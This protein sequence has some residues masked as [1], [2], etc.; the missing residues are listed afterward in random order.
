[1]KANRSCRAI[2]V[3]LVLVSLLLPIGA[4]ADVAD[5]SVWD[6]ILGLSKHYGK[7]VK[8]YN[9]IVDILKLKPDV[10][11]QLVDS[12]PVIYSEIHHADCVNF[13]GELEAHIINFVN[14]VEMKS[15]PEEWRG[16][17][18]SMY[19]DMNGISNYILE[20]SPSGADA[21]VECSFELARYYSELV[22]IGFTVMSA[23][24]EKFNELTRSAFREK[25]VL[26]LRRLLGKC[27]N[28]E[29]AHCET[30]LLFGGYILKKRANNSTEPSIELHNEAYESDQYLSSLYAYLMIKSYFD[31]TLENRVSARVSEVDAGGTNYYYIYIPQAASRFVVTLTESKLFGLIA[32][33]GLLIPYPLPENA[34]VSVFDP[35][36]SL[37]CS[38]PILDGS[39]VCEIGVNGSP[40]WYTIGVSASWRTAAGCT[41]NAHYYGG[42]I[43]TLA[44][45]DNLAAD[46]SGEWITFELRVPY[47]YECLNEQNCQFTVALSGGDGNADLYVDTNGSPHVKLADGD[48]IGC[49]SDNLGNHEACVINPIWDLLRPLDGIIYAYIRAW[50]PFSGVKMKAQLVGPTHHGL[51]DFVYG[52][53]CGAGRCFFGEY[54][55]EENPMICVPAGESC[56]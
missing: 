55:C 28:D 34:S 12:I 42:E 4:R 21:H 15:T 9:S 50:E 43:F 29:E 22:V 19:P 45:I 49:I 10:L 56:Y 6:I 7:T 53:V 26:T 51:P 41:L 37:V 18:D 20:G 30:G 48:P 14:H 38:S 3:L 44:E 54:C 33:A 47:A 11:Q 5:V 13:K 52:Q 24:P 25:A 8:I 27:C 1:M 23:A 2:I 40:G 32:N 17:W 35:Q 31:D 46:Y 39:A 16:Y 36:N